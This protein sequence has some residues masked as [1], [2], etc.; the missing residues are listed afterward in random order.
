VALAAGVFYQRFKLGEDFIDATAMHYG[1]Q[2]SKSFSVLTL[3][4]GLGFDTAN[5]KVEYEPS[6]APD[7]RIKLDLDAQNG[8]RAT[9]GVNLKLAIFNLNADY[10]IGAQSAFCAG[11]GLVF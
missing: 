2:A 7:E 9:L 1:V 11:F 8:M 6:S 5:I 4:G 3:Y 10:S